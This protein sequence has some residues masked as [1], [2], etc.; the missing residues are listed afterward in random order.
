MSSSVGLTTRISVDA[1][2]YS[3]ASS[4]VAR[5]E[6]Q[7]GKISD[8]FSDVQALLNDIQSLQAQ[9]PDRNSSQ[10]W[11]TDGDGKKVFNSVAFG[12]DL[13]SFQQHLQ[14]LNRRLEDPY[15]KLGQAQAILHGMQGQDLPEAER[16]DAD[17]I[18]K[19][20]EA[21]TKAMNDAIAALDDTRKSSE[22]AGTSAGDSKIEIR[23]VEKKVEI[24]LASDP[25]FRDVIR[26]FALMAQMV[27]DTA[28]AARTA[29]TVR[30]PAGIPGGGL[31]PVSTP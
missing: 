4:V 13:Q 6:S 20:A 28:N 5:I 17:R 29:R 15:R 25:S 16:R 21:A 12:K 18:Q 2:Q 24:K 1:P 7:I 30:I 31:P 26:A 10:Y 19:A 3:E 27:G 8:L 22:E 14:D 9:A 23:V 11:S